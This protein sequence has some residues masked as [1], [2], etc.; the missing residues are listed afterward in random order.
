MNNARNLIILLRHGGLRSR[1]GALLLPQGALGREENLAAHLDVHYINFA[2]NLLDALPADAAYLTLTT[3]KLLGRLDLLAN[4]RTERDCLLLANFDLPLSRVT[5]ESRMLLWN[6][7]L[8]DFPY[9]RN[10]LILSLPA[11][12]PHSALLPEGGLKQ[13]WVTSKRL[14]PLSNCN[15]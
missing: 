7:L 12:L 3:D 5:H 9:K 10:A 14:V 13:E 15:P 1:I 8:L 6:R 2:T 11:I 4:T